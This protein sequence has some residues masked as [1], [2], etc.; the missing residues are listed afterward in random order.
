M[1]AEILV[2]NGFA[3]PV[4]TAE[5]MKILEQCKEQG[6]AQTGDNV[7]KS[8]AYI[9]NCCGCCCEMMKAIRVMGLR[10]AIVTS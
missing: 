2:K 1:G 5:A 10:N 6:L 4:S 9:C 3:R 8:A 7:K